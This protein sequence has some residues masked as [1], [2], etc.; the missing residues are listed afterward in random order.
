MKIAIMSDSHDRWDYLE[1]AIE[2]ANKEGC[3]YLLFACDLISPQ[4]VPVL[5]KFKG[6]VIFVW[7]NNEGERAGLK[8]KFEDL[9][10][11]E[12]FG[13]TYKGELSGLKIFMNHYPQKVESA[14]K[15]GNYDLCIFG[16]T[17]QYF[18]EK[19]GCWLINPGEIQGYSSGQ[20]TFSIF[21]SEAKKPEK[22]RIASGI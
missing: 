9:K 3:G 17:H 1:K 4:G 6:K 14:A 7:G 8:R 2:I 11:V 20:T 18:Q 13:D 15:S 12:F 22:R 21:D 5:E 10:K 19:V 16:H